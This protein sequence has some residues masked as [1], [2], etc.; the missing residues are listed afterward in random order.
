[1]SKVEKYLKIRER[2]DEFLVSYSP[3]LD[4]I[5]LMATI[6]SLVKSAFPS[7]IFVGFYLMKEI[8]GEKVLEIGPYQ[9]D[10]L[11]CGRIY[12]GDGVCGKAAQLKEIQLVP[13][14]LEYPGY[15]ACDSET[16]SEIVLPLF[17]DSEV[18]AVFD[19]DHGELNY[20]DDTDKENLQLLLAYIP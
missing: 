11:A 10:V 6:S 5:G 4:K 7:L 16:K 14:V 12:P 20:F 1:M 9:G 8:H 15:I 18:S 19:L 2:L 13:D 17:Q 3:K